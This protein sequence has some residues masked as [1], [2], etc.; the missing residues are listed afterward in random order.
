DSYGKDFPGGRPDLAEVFHAIHDIEG[1]KRIRFMTSY[2]A[3]MTPRIIQ[4]VAEL[5]KVCEHVHLPC[6]AGDDHTLK[7]MHRTYTSGYYRKL[8]GRI[9]STVPNVA[10]STDVIVGFPGETDEQ[11]RNTY[12][13][14]EELRLDT[15]HVACYSQRPGTEAARTLA[16]DVPQEVK[17]ARLKEIEGLQEHVLAEINESLLGQPVQVLVEDDASK[18]NRTGAP[19]W[20]GRTRQNK[21][22]YFPAGERDLRGEEVEVKV[23]RVSPWALQGE[24]VA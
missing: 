15:V 9:R 18:V 6:Q 10:I 16:D 24:L 19:Q 1:L 22:M 21:L 13:L 14:L 4:A 11:F 5:P 2:P 8:I 3:D 12:R 20:R 7:T 17:K 23:E